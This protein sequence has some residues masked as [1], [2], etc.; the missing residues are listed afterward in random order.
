MLMT[1]RGRWARP[2]V[3]VA[4]VILSSCDEKPER[5]DAH[6]DTASVMNAIAGGPVT[7]DSSET[8]D[9][10]ILADAPGSRAYLVSH[11]FKSP[12]GAF[13]RDSS[14]IDWSAHDSTGW[15]LIWSSSE[16]LGA[17]PTATLKDFNGDGTADLFWSIDYED[18]IGGMVVVRRPGGVTELVPDVK[19]CLPPGVQTT[20]HQT[21]VVAYL[22]GA[23]S[24]D[25]CAGAPGRA[26]Q[27]RFQITWPQFYRIEGQSL[28]A[29]RREPGFYR[30]LSARYRRDAAELQRLV[31]SPPDT[32]ED[33]HLYRQCPSDTPA[34]M[35]KLADSALALAK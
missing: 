3:I 30:D 6:A 9:S 12:K 29:F 33:K 21:L 4:V 20:G 26:C 1:S 5:S 13:W 17:L 22:S 27:A 34:K 7:L 25:D 24:P 23:F 2:I 14:V 18:L 16:L 35:Q 15:R 8:T 11:R 10:V 32:G 31:D 19:D 28:V